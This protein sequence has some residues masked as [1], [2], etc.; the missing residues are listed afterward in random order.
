MALWG[1]IDNAAN[2]PKWTV[3]SGLGAANSTGYAPV[4]SDLFQNTAISA[5]KTGLVLGVEGVNTV[6]IADTT[7]QNSNGAGFGK[8]AHVGWNFRKQGTGYVSSIAIA[9]G[10]Q[11][12]NANAFL[13][14]TGGGG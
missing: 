10:G 13:V 2:T 12:Y 14:F 9:G 5:W 7:L 4:G 8:A 3:G 1:A 11:A 6:E